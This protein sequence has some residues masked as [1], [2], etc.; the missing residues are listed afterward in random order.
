MSPKKVCRCQEE[1][2]MSVLQA[3]KKSTV[4]TNGESDLPNRNTVG[5]REERKG[6]KGGP[7]LLNLNFALTLTTARDIASRRNY[8]PHY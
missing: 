2:R 3:Y 5:G 7:D 8:R 6:R 1:G 4:S